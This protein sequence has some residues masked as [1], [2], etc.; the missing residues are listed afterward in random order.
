MRNHPQSAQDIKQKINPIDFYESEQGKLLQHKGKWKDAG[1]CPFHAD[2]SCGS[3]F[4]EPQGGGYTCF[5]CGAKGGD[6]IAFVMQKYELSFREALKKL[7]LDWRI[8]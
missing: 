1:L 6:I 5:S 8:S 2:R 3:F 4:I 7:A